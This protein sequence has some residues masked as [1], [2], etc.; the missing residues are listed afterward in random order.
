MCPNLN[1]EILLSEW[2]QA[3]EIFLAHPSSLQLKVQVQKLQTVSCTGLAAS[4]RL[5]LAL[6]CWDESPVPVVWLTPSSES[7]ERLTQDLRAAIHSDQQKAVVHFPEQDDSENT[8]IDPVRLGILD[9]L[10]HGNC[11]LIITSIRALLQTTLSPDD[12]K[13]GRFEI[14]VAN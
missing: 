11:G 6:A 14:K 5:L 3:L 13:R 8:V 4:S 2:K 9:R 1:R 7:A 10:D 12:L